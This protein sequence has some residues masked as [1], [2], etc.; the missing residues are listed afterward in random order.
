M[1]A[2]AIRTAALT[3]GSYAM[4]ATELASRL[5]WLGAT[6]LTDVPPYP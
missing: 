6:T 1:T 2:G 5:A 3:T 4:T